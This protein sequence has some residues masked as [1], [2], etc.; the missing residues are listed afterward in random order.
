MLEAYLSRDLEAIVRLANESMSMEDL[1]IENIFYQRFLID[2]NIKM[3]Q[4]MVPLIDK[5]PSFF[6]VGA[7]HLTG[8]AGVLRL[9]EQQGYSV[10]A[11]H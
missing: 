5:G 2:R 3:V 1:D 8:K 11:V 10:S 4:R 6:A 7:M 9:L